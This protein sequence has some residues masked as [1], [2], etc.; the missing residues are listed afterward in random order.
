MRIR[1]WLVVPLCLIALCLAQLL[2][3]HFVAAAYASGKKAEGHKAEKGGEKGGALSSEGPHL[4]LSPMMAPYQTSAGIAY[5][6]LMIE[7]EVIGAAGEGEKLDTEGNLRQKQ[8]CFIIPLIHD[9]LLEY[10]FK[11]NLTS[12]DFYGERRDVLQKNMFDALIAYV[13]KGFFVKL[14]LLGDNPPPL[15]PA[16]Q[17]LSVQC[18]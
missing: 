5:Q 18:R 11:A 9:K 8:A 15:E 13:G 10:L 1:F 7:V 6:P 16:S 3:V 12:A 4:R 14:T 2:G 17:T